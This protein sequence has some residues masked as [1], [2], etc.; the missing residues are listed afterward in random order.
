MVAA[1][2]ARSLWAWPRWQRGTS[3]AASPRQA[4]SRCMALVEF[5]EAHSRPGRIG[6]G[7]GRHLQPLQARTGGRIVVAVVHPLEIAAQFRQA[8][9]LGQ[10]RDRGEQHDAAGHDAAEQQRAAAAT[11][12]GAA[13]HHHQKD[14]QS[15]P[16]SAAATEQDGQHA[17]RQSERR[18]A[19]AAR[20]PAE[21]HHD[22]QHQ[23][24]VGEDDLVGPATGAARTGHH[25]GQRQCGRGQQSGQR[26]APQHRLRWI[27]GPAP[28]PSPGAGPAAGR[29]RRWSV[30][31]PP[32]GSRPAPPAM[33]RWRPTPPPA[34]ASRSRGWPGPRATA[35]AGS[36]RAAAGRKATAPW[37]G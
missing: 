19:P 27:H 33:A 10:G 14:Q 13:D 7:A 17:Q 21:D 18:P 30:P 20:R 8:H 31:N 15:G 23:D 34:M 16:G 28:G 2:S 3:R 35:P 24:H 6:E 5:A 12:P 22:H 29:A 32:A 1:H 37:A 4:G 36:K 11:A 25:L 9:L 26:A